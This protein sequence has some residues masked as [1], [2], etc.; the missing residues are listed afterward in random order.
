MTDD[1]GIKPWRHDFFALL[2]RIER[3]SATAPRIGDGLSLREEFVLLGQD[4][5][6][7]FP[8][9]T[10]SRIDRDGAGRMRVFVRFL[11]LLGPQGPLPLATTEE[12]RTWALADDDAFA[13]FADL[14]NHRFLQLFYRAWADARPVAQHDRPHDDRFE[15]YIG[16]MVG[17][18]AP[19]Y[20]NRDHLPDIY[21]LSFAGLLAPAARS[22][23]RLENFLAGVFAVEIEVEQLVGSWLGLERSDQTSLGR[24]HCRLGTDASIGES[25]FSLEDKI[26]IHI[27]AADMPQYR[28]FLP[29]GDLCVP[30]AD[31]V[32]FYIGQEQEWDVELSLPAEAVAPVRLGKSGELGW[33]SWMGAAAPASDPVLP[34]PGTRRRDAR[35]QPAIHASSRA[36]RRS[37]AGGCPP[38]PSPGGER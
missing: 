37:L 38:A 27:A 24:A 7:E 25:V 17:I 20:R 31:A 18:G 1:V 2:R 30:L 4:P 34:S 16:S 36:N 6:L 8:A 35:F 33:T 32:S 10:I 12:A 23:N 3:D 21:K 19:P 11:G 22:A 26:R 13:R 14:F 5:Y 15:A 29:D 28:R 9:S